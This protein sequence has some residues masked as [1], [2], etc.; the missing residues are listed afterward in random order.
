MDIQ[1]S[2]SLLNIHWSLPNKYLSY[3]TH[4][5]SGFCQSVSEHDDC[6][7]DDDIV[8]VSSGNKTLKIF[9]AHLKE[10][11]FYKAAVRPC[12]GNTCLSPVWSKG[13]RIA[14]PMDSTIIKEVSVRTDGSCLNIHMSLKRLPCTSSGKRSFAGGYRWALFTD[15][16]GQHMISDWK[17]VVD[18][19]HPSYIQ[20]NNT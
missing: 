3:V 5:E 6:S 15:E 7:D 18:K 12:F 19:S 1:S 8:Y 14:N 11:G 13:I 4:Y 10:E 17:T 9:H 2:T 16:I 20:V